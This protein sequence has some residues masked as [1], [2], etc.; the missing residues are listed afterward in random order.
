MCA[1]NQYCSMCNAFENVCEHSIFE[2]E[3]EYGIENEKDMELYSAIIIRN[4]I[5]LSV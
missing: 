3:Y 1:Y 5:Q 2:Y 4:G